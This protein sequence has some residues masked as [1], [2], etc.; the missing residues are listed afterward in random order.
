M[1]YSRPAERAGALRLHLNENTGGC[2]PA[3]VDA[4]R[5]ISSQDIACYP[6]YAALSQECA[7]YLGVSEP[8]L[9]LTNGLD[10]GLMAVTLSVFAA[11][12]GSG[13]GVPEALIPLPA[14][15]M[16]SVFV[17]AAGGRVVAIDPL[18]RFEFPTR[19]V[20]DAITDGTRLI[21]LTNPNNPTGQLIPRQTIRDVVRC[22]T[23]RG[24][25]RHR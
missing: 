7:E 13:H 21:F 2:S 1:S 24:D 14:F 6:D 15:E 16:Y 5:Q 18:E 22:C 10:E 25:D 8:Q 9:V 20:S 12:Q 19:Q 17:N 23:C 11:V 4:I 3:V